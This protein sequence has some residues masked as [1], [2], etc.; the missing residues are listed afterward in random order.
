MHLHAA[1]IEQQA[2]ATETMPLG[3]ETGM[4]PSERAK[5]GQWIAEG[6]KEEGP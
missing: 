6:A 5:L 1:Q 2:V 4:T 3:N